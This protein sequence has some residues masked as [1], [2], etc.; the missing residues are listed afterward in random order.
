MDNQVELGSCEKL[1]EIL[2][3]G[4]R[5]K[6]TTWFCAGVTGISRPLQ[7]RKKTCPEHTN[8]IF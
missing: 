1:R 8:D 7:D 6:D 4:S 3:Q 5:E 2:V